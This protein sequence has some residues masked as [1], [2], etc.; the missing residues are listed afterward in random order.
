MHS[1]TEKKTIYNLKWS[2]KI[3]KNVRS[4]Y[5]RLKENT[6]SI[7]LILENKKENLKIKLIN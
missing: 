2:A 1:D 4:L 7:L 6:I 3:T 5:S